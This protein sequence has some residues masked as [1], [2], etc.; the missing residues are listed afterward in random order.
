MSKYRLPGAADLSG[1]FFGSYEKAQSTAASINP[2]GWRIVA[3]PHIEPDGTNN[4]DNTSYTVV[5]DGVVMC[6]K[7]AVSVS[8]MGGSV[9][10]GI[11]DVVIE[12]PEGISIELN[13]AGTVDLPVTIQNCTMR[14]DIAIYNSS[15]IIQDSNLGAGVTIGGMYV[16]KFTVV[17]NAS[18]IG[19]ES[20]IT[21]PFN[22]IGD[23][24]VVIDNAKIGAK[25]TVS[26]NVGVRNEVDDGNT[27]NEPL[28]DRPERT[29]VDDSIIRALNGL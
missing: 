25:C 8:T 10:L 7:G 14:G 1:L 21:L 15:A 11:R 23:T 2:S 5:H 16:G 22:R 24:Q 13:G 4:P 18:S 9:I 26:A 27:I 12:D 28:P 6:F 17:V 3:V 20:A 29:L 19:D